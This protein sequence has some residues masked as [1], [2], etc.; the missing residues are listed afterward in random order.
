MDDGISSA[1][2]SKRLREE[3]SDYE[4]NE[5]SNPNDDLLDENMVPDSLSPEDLAAK[6]RKRSQPT[7]KYL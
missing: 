4:D 1:V 5:D 3:D 2:K 6:R 7:E